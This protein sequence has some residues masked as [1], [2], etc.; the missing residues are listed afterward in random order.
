MNGREIL[1]A[2]ADWMER[3]DWCQRMYYQGSSDAPTACCVSGSFI[4]AVGNTRF[5]GR[6]AARILLSDEIGIGRRIEPW[7]DR[8]DQT[9]ANV[10]A[11]MRRAAGRE[12]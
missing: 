11:T 4:Y 6:Q 2:A 8:D 1:L 10:I 9:K 12:G 3:N 7:N 5:D